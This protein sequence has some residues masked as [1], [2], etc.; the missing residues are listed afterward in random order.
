MKIKKSA[1]DQVENL[2]KGK[3]LAVAQIN[4]GIHLCLDAVSQSMLS[5]FSFHPQLDAFNALHK[6]IVS[7]SKKLSVETLHFQIS[8]EFIKML[9]YSHPDLQQITPNRLLYLF[10]QHLSKAFIYDCNCRLYDK[11]HTV[12]SMH[13]LARFLGYTRN[14]LNY[15]Q[16]QIDQAFKLQWST[17]QAKC[18]ALQHNH[19][20][21][22]MFW[23]A[24]H[25]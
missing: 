25:E 14:Q 24:E 3:S 6:K 13:L 17:L 9:Y 4:K 16:S 8:D 18:D 19:L 5:P 15:R 1:S 11:P 12:I 20:D 10:N 21:S 22:S 23:R 7:Q 2:V